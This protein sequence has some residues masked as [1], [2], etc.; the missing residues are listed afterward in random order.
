MCVGQQR[1]VLSLQ[2]ALASAQPASM[3]TTKQGHAEHLAGPATK[4]GMGPQRTDQAMPD[5]PAAQA[6]AVAPHSAEMSQHSAGM[7]ESCQ[8]AAVAS[9][10]Q[11]HEA[12]G[13]LGREPGEHPRP[14]KGKSRPPF[15]REMLSRQ[16]AEAERRASARKRRRPQAAQGAATADSSGD[17]GAASAAARWA[18]GKRP[19]GRDTSRPPMAGAPPSKQAP[20]AQGRQRS[21]KQRHGMTDCADGVRSTS[22]VEAARARLQ[23]WTREQGLGSTVSGP[24]AAAQTAE[25]DQAPAKEPAAAVEEAARHS[26]R[27]TREP[28]AQALL[29]IPKQL[30]ACAR[31]SI[32]VRSQLKICCIAC[33]CIV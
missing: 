15:M 10:L 4:S 2:Q 33:P 13:G 7:E 19:L 22:S 18:R 14:G 16:A 3:A 12:L 20:A 9:D 8:A 30:A 26:K 29:N 25:A 5:Q 28:Y 21:Q 27:R 32:K 1:D 17:A 11:C 24:G 31:R 6:C 23:V